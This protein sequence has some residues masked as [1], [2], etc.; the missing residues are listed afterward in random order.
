MIEIE[1]A[2]H[3]TDALVSVDVREFLRRF[4]CICL[5]FGLPGAHQ[6]DD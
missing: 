2:W 6:A 3:E 4:D 1:K 5:V